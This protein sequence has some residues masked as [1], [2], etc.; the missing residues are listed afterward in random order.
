MQAQRLPAERGTWWLF[1]GFK[2]FRRNP[3]LITSLTL[4]YLLLVQS[5]VTLL[6]GVGPILLPV[7]L[8]TLT[9]IVAN[10]CRLV[11]EG[12]MPNRAGLL[13]GIVGNGRAMLRLGILQLAGAVVLMLIN[14]A[15]DGG[16]G[17]DPFASMDAVGPLSAP[18]TGEGAAGAVTG[19]GT[20]TATA[21]G[22]ATGATDGPP[23][24][25]PDPERDAAV[26]AALMRLM[27]LSM[28]LILAFWFAPFLTGWEAV[29]PAKS[30]FFS[31]IAA[32]RNWRAM[33]MFAFGSLF[34]AGVVPG[35]FLILA[36][37]ITGM[38]LPVA[39]V[40]LRVLL[41][42]L[43]APVLTASIY[44]SYRDIFRSS[45]DDNA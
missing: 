25:T 45:V 26:L 11:D 41:I 29:S 24:A 39:F 10:G 36:S 3:P 30:L 42:F 37:Q 1:E 6:P 43:V 16:D 13:H 44:I 17:T 9:L 4:I 8:P 38:A 28:P 33:G 31:I 40:A 2:L 34:V 7:V 32:W 12:G 20:G 19:M 18:D 5:L 35:I 22:T 21:D 15:M 27:L 23:P 14:F